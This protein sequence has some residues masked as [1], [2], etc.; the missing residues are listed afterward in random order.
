MIFIFDADGLH[1][2]YQIELAKGQSE[3]ITCKT[4][5]VTYILKCT[6][7]RVRGGV[8]ELKIEWLN[9]ITARTRYEYYSLRG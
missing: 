9:T 7:T 5:G 6:F 1:H 3:V 4:P 2:Y 8:A